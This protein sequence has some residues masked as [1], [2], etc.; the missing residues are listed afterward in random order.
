MFRGGI[1]LGI[2]AAACAA[3]VAATYLG[4]KDRIDKNQKIWLERS[5]RPALAGVFFDSGLTDSRLVFPP[6]HDLPGSDAAIIY[7]VYAGGE[8]VAALFAIS[9]R[10]YSGPIRLLVGIDAGGAVT[11]VRVLEHRET[12]GLGDLVESGK[13]D[14]INQFKGRRLGDPQVSGWAIKRDGGEFDQLTGASVT[15]R[16][17]V[18]AV[19]DTLIYF[20]N[21]A[22][23]VLLARETQTE[24]ES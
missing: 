2:I 24:D 9:A 5:L 4:T 13:T 11:G 23:R 12:P 16:A 22:E 19:R 8:P 17:I 3:L 20:S 7:R 15:P 10:G 1:T 21:N 6:P 18:N 14:W